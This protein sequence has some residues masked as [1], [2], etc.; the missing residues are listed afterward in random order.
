MLISPK[1][2]EYYK[3]EKFITTYKPS[4]EIR[5][6]DDTKIKNQTFHS[7]KNRFEY[8]VNIDRI[9]VSNKVPLCKKVLNILL[10]TKMMKKGWLQL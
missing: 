3:I 4:K 7:H 1:K 8:D 9:V 2:E 5:T 10:E 6:F